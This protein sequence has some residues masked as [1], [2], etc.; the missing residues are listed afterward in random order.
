MP[1]LRG[2]DIHPPLLQ[3]RVRGIILKTVSVQFLLFHPPVL[4]PDFNLA[5][6]EIEH[7]RKL[8]TFLLVDVNTE[9]E[10]PLQFS[11]LVFGVWTSL[12]TGSL[13]T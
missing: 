5:V 13:S 12:L 7:P 3:H 8:K 11:D 4:K 1:C 9:K 10:L 6:G 2:D